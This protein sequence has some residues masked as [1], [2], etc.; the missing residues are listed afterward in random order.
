MM[1]AEGE[2]GLLMLGSMLF[3]VALATGY[4]AFR[5]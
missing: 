3:T 4:L 2:G 5:L 1:V